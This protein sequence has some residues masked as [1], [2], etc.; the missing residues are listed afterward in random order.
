MEFSVVD[1]ALLNSLTFFLVYEAYLKLHC[2]WMTFQEVWA[3]PAY[4][5]CWF[6]MNS[7]MQYEV[8][9]FFSNRSLLEL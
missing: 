7:C 9:C 4:T 5:Y 8:C 2:L 6:L 3:D 1:P